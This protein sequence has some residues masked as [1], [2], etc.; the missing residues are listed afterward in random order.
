MQLEIPALTTLIDRAVPQVAP[1]MQLVVRWRGTT[2]YERTAGWIDPETRSRPTQPDTLFDLASV[3][4]LFVVTLCMMLVEAGAVALD[5]PLA[6]VLPEFS[7][8]RP[9]QPYADPQ[10]TGRLIS[11]EP[12]ATRIDAGS[13][14]LRQVLTH[15]SGLP[16]WCPLF[17][18]PTRAAAWQMALMTPFAYRPGTRV[19]YSDIGLM[20]L[21]LAIERLA[22]QPLDR[23]VAQRISGPLSLR[24]TGF[25]PLDQPQRAAHT[26]APTEICAWRNRRVHGQVHDE[27]A[28]ALGGIAGHAGLFSTAADVARFGQSLLDGGAPLLD[29]ATVAEMTRPHV[30]RAAVRRGLGF[31]LWSPDPEA[32]SHPFSRRTF[33]H[34]GFTGT[35]L[36]IDPERRLVVA[37]LTNDVYH[38][39]AER[40][41][42]GLRLAV[43]QAVVEAI[44]RR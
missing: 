27:N 38:G 36:W 26:I 15:T 9:T 20:L 25:V 43:H 30:E 34:T 21:G 2:V 3:T 5:Q 23:L 19:L 39:R 41:I 32:S 16:P 13:I 44:E 7:G 8:P 35:S 17:R 42:G 1:A 29:A 24:H 14:T 4:K 40:R 10:Q 33:G 11:L 18:Q 12:R 6:S 28:A 37:L 22:G 31:A